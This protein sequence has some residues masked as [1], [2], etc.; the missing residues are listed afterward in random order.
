VFDE[1]LL[2]GTKHG[3]TTGAGASYIC[4]KCHTR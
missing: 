1:P 3:D 4:M 2:R